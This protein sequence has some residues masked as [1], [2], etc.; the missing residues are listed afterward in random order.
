MEFTQEEQEMINTIINTSLELA[1]A[2]P[3]TDEEIMAKSDKLE[4][5][6][7]ALIMEKAKK[8]AK[9]KI[10]KVMASPK[11]WGPKPKPRGVGI[12]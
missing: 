11:L 6:H 3:F 10:E 8:M 5:A 7:E 4:K 9:E 12:Y 2:H 1:K